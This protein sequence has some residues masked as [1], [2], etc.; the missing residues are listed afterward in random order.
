MSPIF[1]AKNEGN[2]LINK[3]K[4]P[5]KYRFEVKNYEIEIFSREIV[6]NGE[7]AVKTND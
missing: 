2:C 4:N 3:K 1:G 7:K 5:E 6:I